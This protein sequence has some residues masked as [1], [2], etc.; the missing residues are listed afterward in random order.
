MPEAQVTFISGNWVNNL[1]PK[2]QDHYYNEIVNFFTEEVTRTV[3]EKYNKP[4]AYKY[5]NV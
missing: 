5:K 3:L 1:T 4:I 2:Q